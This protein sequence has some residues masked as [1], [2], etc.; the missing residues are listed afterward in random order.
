MTSLTQLPGRP[1][2]LDDVAAL[3]VETPLRVV[4]YGGVPGDDEVSIYAVKALTEKSAHALGFDESRGRWQR[5]A[6]VTAADLAAADSRLDDVLDKWV[7]DQYGA[8]FDV[9]RT[10]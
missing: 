8:R 1:L 6:S 5:L 10:A 3:N 2:G 4:P 9:L 7:Q